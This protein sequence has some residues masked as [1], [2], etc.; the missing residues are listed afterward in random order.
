LI[1][2]PDENVVDKLRQHGIAVERLTEP[3][4][5]SVE[6]FEITEVSPA[7]RLNQGH[8]TTSVTGSYATVEREFPAGTYF[9]TTAQALGSVAAYLLEPESDDGMVVWNFFDR[10][11]ATQW[12]GGPRTFPVYKVLSPVTLATE[13]LEN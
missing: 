11:L 2:V 8:Y 9:V 13:G 12:G 1:T 4:T 6:A 3:A 7:P 5:L 10:H